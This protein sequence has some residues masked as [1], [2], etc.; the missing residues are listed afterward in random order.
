MIIGD[1]ADPIE[2]GP[3][4]QLYTKSFYEFI[5]KPRLNQGGIF[6]TQVCTKHKPESVRA[7]TYMHECFSLCLLAITRMASNQF[8]VFQ[9]FRQGLL[10]FS[11]IQKFFLV[12]TIL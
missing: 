4:Y 7:H 6:V 5:V 8:E 11:A 2:G 1:L 9:H 10:G 12:S 3:C